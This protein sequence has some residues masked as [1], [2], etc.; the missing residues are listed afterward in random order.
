VEETL[1]KKKAT[2]GKNKDKKDVCAVRSYTMSQVKGKDTKIEL[3]FRKALWH[4]GIRYRKNYKGLPGKPDIT[5][6]KHKIAI[7]CD[8]EFWHG[9]DWNSTKG[10]LKTR[11]EFWVEKIERNIER[12][13]GNERQLTTLGWTILRFWGKDIEKNLDL[14]VAEVKDAILQS[15]VDSV[16]AEYVYELAEFDETWESVAAEQAPD[17]GRS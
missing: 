8:G 16:A 4:S 15:R 14:C 13:T 2:Y 1:S 10:K 12:D 3:I 7:F 9:K 17:Y 5:I 11:R 6:T